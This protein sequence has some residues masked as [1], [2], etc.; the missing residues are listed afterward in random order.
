MG[1]LPAIEQ[2]MR[3]LSYLTI[4]H[5]PGGEYLAG[6]LAVNEYAYPRECRYTEPVVLTPERAALLGDNTL[7]FVRD[8]L[9]LPALF[10]RGS[11]AWQL[12]DDAALIEHCR[13]PF[14]Y[15]TRIDQLDQ[16]PAA[17]YELR[18]PYDLLLRPIEHQPAYR[19]R[20]SRPLPA[21]QGLLQL[22]LPFATH[23]QL[24]EP[25]SRLRQFLELKWK[26]RSLP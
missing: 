11:R 6:C 23:F 3:E 10:P 24:T 15:L 13:H 9:L 5:R 12:V 21:A 16:G 22:L 4:L 19:L 20:S 1:V 7:R 17:A 14:I 8:E 26:R 2:L 18:S 25:F